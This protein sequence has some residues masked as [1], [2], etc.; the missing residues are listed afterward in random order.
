MA[1]AG[2]QATAR[3]RR[4]QWML[5][6][7]AAAVVAVGAMIGLGGVLRDNGDS[8]GD[9]VERTSQRAGRVLGEQTAGVVLTMWEDFQCPL[10][11]R[12]N[13]TVVARIVQDYVNTGR[14]PLPL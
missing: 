9:G 3:K 7:A 8:A 4:T 6:P 10:C 11:K 2:A 14:G 12:A 13:D 5:M 1:R